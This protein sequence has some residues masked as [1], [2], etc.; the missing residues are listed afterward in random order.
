M[1]S[2]PE[3]TN[4]THKKHYPSSII[5]ITIINNPHH[6]KSSLLNDK[7]KE[8]PQ[9]ITSKLTIQKYISIIKI[10]LP[11][12][13]N[14]KLIPTDFILSNAYLPNHNH[15]LP[16]FCN[17]HPNAKIV[18]SEHQIFPYNTQNTTKLSTNIN[19]I[20]AESKKNL[21][22]SSNNLFLRLYR[23]YQDLKAE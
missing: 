21:I 16:S 12:S 4:P 14:H 8:Q 5:P 13:K 22:S 6:R 20:P 23:L 9:K 17:F 15:K 3:S 7:Y 1:D 19:H 18:I 11:D 10:I 2:P